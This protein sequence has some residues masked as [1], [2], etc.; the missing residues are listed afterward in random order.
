ME[1]TLQNASK[2]Q[3]SLLPWR[4]KSS[5]MTLH[6]VIQIMVHMILSYSPGQEVDFEYQKTMDWNNKH[7]VESSKQ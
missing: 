7:A 2:V 1:D 5:I 3:P 6:Y 4:K